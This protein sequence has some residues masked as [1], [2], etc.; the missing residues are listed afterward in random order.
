MK[1]ITDEQLR[2]EFKELM[3][4]D[5]A[6]GLYG[7]DVDEARLELLRIPKSDWSVVVTDADINR[8]AKKIYKE[9][10]GDGKY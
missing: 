8:M 1:R 3:A 4:S 2:A 10:Y 7:L 6:V 5:P 9:M